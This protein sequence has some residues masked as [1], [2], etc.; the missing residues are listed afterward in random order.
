MSASSTDERSAL[1]QFP[2]P[3]PS[4]QR[5]IQPLSDAYKQFCHLV[6][7]RP[8]DYPPGKTYYPPE[9]SLY[10][11][12]VQHRRSQGRMY[13]LTSALINTM[14]LTQVVLGAA[15][16]G[17]GASNSPGWIITVIGALNTIIAGLVA[18]M[19]SRG[20]PMRARMF[21]DDLERVVDEI[22]SSA[23]MWRG[24]SQGIHGYDAIDTDESVTVRSEVARLTRLYDRAVKTNTINDP[25][26][27]GGAGVGSDP[28]NSGLR[29]RP[30]QPALLA[31]PAPATAPVVDGNLAPAHAAVLSPDPDESPAT[32][33][34]PHSKNDTPTAGTV[35]P[36]EREPPK[37]A[38]GAPSIFP[39]G[40]SSTAAVPPDPRPPNAI[41]TPESALVGAVATTDPD[42]S[43]ASAARPP[44]VDRTK[45]KK[46]TT[47]VTEDP[48][49]DSEQAVGG[50]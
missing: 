2:G 17:M 1:L 22:H 6:G 20:Q 43:P 9:D 44:G 46:Q 27:Y 49:R 41:P 12:A 33:W 14:L 32:K 30:G 15:L 16:T 39:D 31:A 28:S 8:T 35:K 21:R 42:E 45:S 4:E 19:K 47:K 50:A 3:S 13:A 10:Y 5:D 40:D 48:S 18:F 25:D 24:I 36:T 11:R 7:N 34:P 29:S 37:A 38:A 26:Y 23:I